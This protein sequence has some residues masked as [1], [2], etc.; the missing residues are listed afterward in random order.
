MDKILEKYFGATEEEPANPVLVRALEYILS[1]D[2]A[3]DLGA[4]A[5]RDS[6]YL[7]DAGFRK[8]T[9]VDKEPATE[10]IAK[11]LSNPNLICII[12][13]FENFG[14]PVEEYDL[15]N[16]QFSLPFNPPGSLISILDKIK[17]SLK[18]G[19]IFAG[20]LF[21]INDE[22]NTGNKKRSFHT[23]EQV[24]EMFSD[25][26]IIN[27]GEV[28]RDGKTAVG[29]IKHWHFFNIIARRK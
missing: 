21:G 23:H 16:A 13:S 2:S 12:S 11:G 24:K 8:V 14:F 15:V 22:W 26:D 19:G 20:Q 29:D 25:M 3:L 18:P 1:K 27:F 4:G 9:A 10:E 7:I 28:D 5:L 6:K 17:V